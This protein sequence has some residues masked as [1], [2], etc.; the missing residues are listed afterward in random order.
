MSDKSWPRL[1]GVAGVSGSQVVA[2]VWCSKLM[3][4]SVATPVVTVLSRGVID[5]AVLRI[6]ITFASS[7]SKDGFN[8]RKLKNNS[9]SMLE[10]WSMK[11]VLPESHIQLSCYL[12]VIDRYIKVARSRG[13]GPWEAR[14]PDQMINFR[15]QH[16]V[17]L[18]VCERVIFTTRDGLAGNR[19]TNQQFYRFTKLANELLL[20]FDVIKWVN[21]I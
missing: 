4:M 16:W 18:D 3:V 19:Q 12:R 17:V 14:Q 1:M 20:S 8:Y 9:E 11:L 21:M 13:V 2:E 15:P 5:E 10:T 7:I 6:Q